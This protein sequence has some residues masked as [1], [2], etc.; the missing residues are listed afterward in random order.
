METGSLEMNVGEP[1][2][3]AASVNTWEALWAEKK[4]ARVKKNKSR[5]ENK[6][7]IPNYFE[8]QF[9][10]SPSDYIYSRL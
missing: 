6:L 4:N 5:V 3:E 2:K 10:Q 9:Q 7:A 8:S 1:T